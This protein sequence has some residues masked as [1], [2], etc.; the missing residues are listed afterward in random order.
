MPSQLAKPALQVNPQVPV[1]QVAVALAA[2]GQ[3]IPHTPQWV[4]VVRRST[5]QPL[6]IIPSQLPRPESQPAMA[7]TEATHEAAPPAAVHTRP[8]EPQLPVLTRVSTSQP[9]AAS[10]SQFAKPDVHV[11]PQP[12]AVHVVTALARMGHA[13][14]HVPQWVSE[15][16]VSTSQPLVASPSQS[17]KPVMHDPTVQLPAVH[18]GVAL[19]VEH[20]LLHAP[21]CAVLVPRLTSQPSVAVVLQSAKP[22]LHANAQAPSVQELVALARAGQA[23]PHAPQCST[24]V[25]VLTSQPLVAFMSQSPKGAMQLPMPQP[26][27]IQ[28]G[29]AFSPIHR[30]PQLPQ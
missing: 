20:A 15:L 28:A 30:V 19:G 6:S 9:F 12:P 24:L 4:R 21:Q 3:V 2:P 25:R 7:H 16:R 1:A 26:P 11:K 10:P 14:R 29:T 17:A 8:Q 13:L 23:E 22:M 27:R 5:S 18:E